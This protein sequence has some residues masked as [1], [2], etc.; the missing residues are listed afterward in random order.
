M[1]E[2]QPRQPE[3]Y[4]EKP[5]WNKRQDDT[6]IIFLDKREQAEELAELEAIEAELGLHF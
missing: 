2:R 4:Q 3:Q 5:Y 6:T 1:T